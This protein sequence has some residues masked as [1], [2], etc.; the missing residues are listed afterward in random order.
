MSASDP[1]CQIRNHVK[2]STP[3][4]FIFMMQF[5]LG[6]WKTK[7]MEAWPPQAVKPHIDFL[8]PFHQKLTEAREFGRTEA[9][10]GPGRT[11]PYK[12]HDTSPRSSG[13]TM[14]R[15]RMRSGG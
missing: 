4:K 5:P 8:R 12:R 6:D 2:R 9:L 1:R 10:C 14:P 7:G 3:M 11:T 13:W 15:S